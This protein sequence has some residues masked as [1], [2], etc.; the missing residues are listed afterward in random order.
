M[1]IL[2]LVLVASLLVCSL[3]QSTMAQNATPA[4]EMLLRDDF[5]GRHRYELDGRGSWEF[6]DH[7]CIV[8]GSGRAAFATARL[9]ELDGA[10]IVVTFTPDRRTG[11]SFDSAGIALMR[12]PDN[13]W[14]LLLVEGPDGRRYF[15]LI[16]RYQGLHQA[17]SAH[18]NTRLAS[19]DE[20]TLRNWSYGTAYRLILSLSK[21]GVVGEIND[22][23]GGQFWRRT[24][25]FA[26]GRAV[27]RGRPA[28]LSHGMSGTFRHLEVEGVRTPAL[29]D[30][31]FRRG[32]AGSAAVLSEGDAKPLCALLENAG[33][34]VTPLRWEDAGKGRVPVESLDLLVLA[35]A[36]RLPATAA[37]AVMSYLRAGGKLIAIGAPAF[38]E[39]LFK[40]PGGAGARW[41]T[42]ER[43]DDVLLDL[44]KPRRVSI[45]SWNRSCRNPQR[46][47]AMT[48]DAAE[49]K[50]AMKFSCDLD[51]WDGYDASFANAFGADETLLTFRAK[52]DATTSQL[53]LEFRE[54][55]GSR[56]IATVEL[57]PQWRPYLLRPG[58]FLHW[59]DSK[60]KRGGVADHFNPHN[61]A[62]LVIGLS[63]SHTPKCRAGQHAFWIKDIATA[64]DPGAADLDAHV[65]DLDGISPSYSLH[66]LDESATLRAAGDQRM[67]PAG[68]KQPW[69]SRGYSTNLRASGR[70]LDR[71]QSWRWLPIL[72]SLDARGHNRGALVSLFVGNGLFPG[73]LWANVGM[74]DP[75]DALTPR[76]AEVIARLAKAMARGCFLIEGGSR[77]FSYPDGEKI[78]LGFLASN[79]GHG[80]R[81][82]TGRVEVVDGRG[83]VVFR[84][85]RPLTLAEGTQQRVSW[86]WQP[87][88]FDRR[89]YEV[90]AE[91]LDGDT[92]QDSV[93]HSVD[94]LPP[95]GQE[96]AQ[97]RGSHFYVGGKKWF[98][99]GINYRP[100]DQGG[101]PPT[102]FL[103]RD[104]YDP[105]VVERDLAWM[106]SIGINFLSAIH[107]PVPPNPDEPG[108]FRDLHDFLNR[109]QRH[110]M[111][112]FFFLNNA[113]PLA[114][115]DFEKVKTYITAAGIK[116]HPAIFS[117]ELSW[118]PIFYSAQSAEVLKPDWNAWIVERYGSIASAET[119]W[120]FKLAR[121]KDGCVVTP[122]QQ[123]CTTHGS[124]DRAVAAFRR[125]FSDRLSRGYREII[126]P[127]RAWDPKHLITFRFGACGIPD[128]GRFAHSHSAGV[129]KHVDFMCPEGYNLQTGGWATPTPPDDLR[130][131]GLVTLY[132]RFLS[133]EKPVVWMEFGYTVNGF[134]AVWTPDMTHIKPEQLERQ[135]A[136]FESYYAMFLESGARG[137]AP[138]WLPGG[139]RL[140]ERSDFGVLEPDGTE[141]PACEIMR[142]AHPQFSRV[143]HA[144]PSKFMEVD[145]DAQNADAWQLYGQQYLDAVK[146]GQKPY[147]KTA[148]TGTDS[149]NTPLIAVGNTPCNGHNPP[150][151]LNAEFNSVEIQD[152]NG[153]W[154]EAKNGAV[155]A[156][157][158]GSPV[159]CRASIGNLG[160]AKWL[161]PRPNLAQGGV[162]LAG[163]KE[164]GV[165]FKAPI[166]VDA[167]YLADASVKEFTLVPAVNESVTVSFEMYAEG[168]AW[169]GERRTVSLKP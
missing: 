16:E 30:I 12:D 161:A 35:D 150:K 23:A 118:E 82:V 15:E 128:G 32:E 58:D 85:S 114:G 102:D 139:F 42:R 27:R 91:L 73:T 57:T 146:A 4:L 90:R 110:G 120:A 29:A 149:T 104:I 122:S 74:S 34:G 62:H 76:L 83:K 159:R 84:Q 116:D 94:F 89:G 138:W 152:V 70:G 37:N 141:R 36:R 39:L 21:D 134:H 45:Q 158:R 129:A 106:E 78:E 68:W 9:D 113:R 98:M 18:G 79:A 13:D 47:S 100:N 63:S 156:V 2:R 1:N 38:S 28:L 59:K 107:A 157:K 87:G 167:D 60:A 26:S 151:F 160:E 109:C 117:W 56:W 19:K 168:R 169:F 142:R 140:G 80:E 46:A 20:G 145:F 119:D 6:Q 135:R 44:V 52:G 112:V 125:F 137:A 10:K 153:Q 130:K 77:Y 5:S 48:E 54:R 8:K 162:Y 11:S 92:A 148:G 136:E 86:D 143:V 66:P 103:Q 132:Y 71:G 124:H 69:K 101:R 154:Q 3:F 97:V 131:G 41:V 88:K 53:A 72:E 95:P 127:L 144:K 51:G 126:S 147:L 22:T 93:S 123:L 108:A 43:Y 164:Y 111:K 81:R 121:D 33:F 25:S 65:P 166:A 64:T 105:V 165:E 50:G 24:F 49:G 99:K 75:A 14:R 96:F 67:V 55:D 163:R 133:R 155:V 115:A 40:S 61:A 31:R 7:S 17:Q